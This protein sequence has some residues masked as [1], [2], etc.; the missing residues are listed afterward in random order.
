MKKISRSKL[1]KGIIV[2]ML[3]IF[4]ILSGVG[5]YYYSTYNSI[6]IPINKCLVLEYGTKE[7][8]VEDL[9]GQVDGKVVDIEDSLDTS[10]LGKQEVVVTVEKN[11]IKREVPVVIEVQDNIAPTVEIK[12]DKVSYT[13]G[14]GIDLST[15][16]NGILDQVDGDIS[17]KTDETKEED[18]YYTIE[19]DSN[20]EDVG[21]HMITVSVKDKNGNVTTKYFTVNTKTKPAPVVQ[22]RV[23]AQAPANVAGNSMV[24]L[25]YSL[26]GSPYVHGGSAPGG[27]DCSGLVAYIY[28]QHG[29]NIPQSSGAQAYVGT[30][31]GYANAQPGD[32]IIWGHGSQPTH[33]SIY[34]GNGLIIHATNPSQGVVISG[35][36]YWNTHS[37]ARLLSVRRVS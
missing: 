31:V 36:D 35:V 16:L 34:V 23:Y 30:E 3:G 15:N 4:V 11:Y 9:I 27:F 7:Y 8:N 2:G 24:Q 18:A 12:E 22:Q 6:S 5:Y 1:I 13:Q 28:R 33:S 29:I 10:V 14:D 21:S 37:D 32:I 20:I 25:A 17:I 26:V 19:S